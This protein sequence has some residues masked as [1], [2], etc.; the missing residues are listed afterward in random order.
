M[1]LR[2]SCSDACTCRIYTRKG[3]LRLRIKHKAPFFINL[4]LSAS[5]PCNCG[6]IKARYLRI[7]IVNLN[8]SLNIQCAQTPVFFLK[9]VFIVLAPTSP[10]RMAI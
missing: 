2:F 3:K 1:L 4:T 9:Q 7:S 10:Y 5:P 6:K 8:V